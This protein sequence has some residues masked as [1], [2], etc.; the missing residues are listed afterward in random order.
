M[1]VLTEKS[2]DYQSEYFLSYKGL[3]KKLWQYI[4]YFL[5]Y[6]SVDY[7]GRLTN[8]A[9]P[10]SMAKMCFVKQIVPLQLS[11]FLLNTP[12]I[13]Q[14]QMQFFSHPSPVIFEPLL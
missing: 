2:G 4:Q 8:I 12:S 13:H 3:I 14:L 9:I 5:G 11:V 10:F 1:V 7:S 6:F